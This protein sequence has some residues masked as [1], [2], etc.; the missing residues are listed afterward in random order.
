MINCNRNLIN[1]L[2]SCNLEWYGREYAKLEAAHA[3]LIQAHVEVR[4]ELAEL[5]QHMAIGQKGS[6]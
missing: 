5:K 3:K 2:E 4:R 6:E 1:I